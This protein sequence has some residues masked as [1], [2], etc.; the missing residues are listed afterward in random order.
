MA[1][2]STGTV[3][4]KEEACGTVGQTV[5]CGTNTVFPAKK[6]LA[7]RKRYRR[8]RTRVFHPSVNSRAA[9]NDTRVVTAH[10][11]D[12]VREFRLR[13]LDVPKRNRHAVAYIGCA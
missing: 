13:D 7:A 8:F 9:P 5:L 11:F 3:V 10:Y 12:G 1:A 6:I 2:D 4:K